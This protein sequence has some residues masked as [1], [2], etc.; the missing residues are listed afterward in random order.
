MEVGKTEPPTRYAAQGLTG[1]CDQIVTLFIMTDFDF[2][3]WY[4]QAEPP[5]PDLP[6]VVIHHRQG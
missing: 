3:D 1:H 5:G 2:L 4:A 6:A